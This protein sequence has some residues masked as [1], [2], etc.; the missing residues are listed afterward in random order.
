MRA[1]SVLMMLLALAGAAVSRAAAAQSRADTKS[2]SPLH[3]LRIY[4]VH[5]GNEAAFHARFRDHALRIMARHGFDV[6]ATWESPKENATEFVYVLKWRSQDELKRAWTAFMADEEWAAIKRRTGAEHGT[7]VD[8]I[9]DRLLLPTPYS[10][11]G[12]LWAEGKH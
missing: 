11:R 5:A 2:D 6:L 1:L 4:R 3:Q 12:T 8:G 10:P 7:F 9:E